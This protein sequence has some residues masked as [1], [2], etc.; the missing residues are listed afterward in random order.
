MIS[1]M[2]AA[3]ISDPQMTQ[4]V[5]EGREQDTLIELQFQGNPTFQSFRSHQPNVL[6]VDVVGAGLPSDFPAKLRVMKGVELSFVE[7]VGAR[8]RLMRVQIKLPVRMDPELKTAPKRIRILLPKGSTV[9]QVVGSGGAQAGRQQELA[10]R[11]QKRLQELELSHG[12]AR[13][14]LTEKEEQIERL[15]RR[16]AN[17]LSAQQSMAQVAAKK[18]KSVADAEAARR[19]AEDRAAAALRAVTATEAQV[20]GETDT[21]KRRHAQGAQEQ[22]KSL[23]ELQARR[24][25]IDRL[26]QEQEQIKSQIGALQRATSKQELEAER[27][28]QTEVGLRA[29]V[30]QGQAQVG[31][32]QRTLKGLNGRIRNS[33]K[34][35]KELEARRKRLEKKLKRYTRDIRTFKGRVSALDKVSVGV[36]DAVAKADV[37]ISGRLVV[38]S[39]LSDELKKKRVV[40]ASLERRRVR[41]KKARS[42]LAKTVRSLRSVLK[43]KKAEQTQ[44]EGRIKRSDVAHEELKASL[45]R[46]EVDRAKLERSVARWMAKLEASEAKLKVTEKALV[47]LKHQHKGLAAKVAAAKTAV[48]RVDAQVAQASASV[49]QAQA[50]VKAKRK[51]L[52]RLE[53]QRRAQERHAAALAKKAE[54]ARH[55]AS[56][57]EFKVKK[58]PKAKPVLVAAVAPRPAPSKSVSDALPEAGFGGGPAVQSGRFERIGYRPVGPERVLVRYGGNSQPKLSQASKRTTVLTLPGVSASSKRLRA[59]DTS[60]FGGLVQSIRPRRTRRGLRVELK[61]E[62]GVQFQMVRTAAGV[63]L[64]LR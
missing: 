54:S 46:A 39:E 59:L 53:R 34:A 37:K 9:A 33:E 25:E 17:A 10:G 11:M 47:P 16:L 23:T 62:Q 22:A 7:H 5:L 45:Q 21:L 31:A 49:T 41:Q 30:E 51:Q 55:V 8:T 42:S 15:S 24:R 14:Q 28:V 32:K 13:K 48:A 20:R 29:N 2:L 3:L 61:H 58:T 27:L 52:A 1:L 60:L 40:L 64:R 44:I 12:K 63:E 26:L 35:S 38:R 50:G 43:K 57:L 18:D 56:A 19:K 36:R 6:V 4:V